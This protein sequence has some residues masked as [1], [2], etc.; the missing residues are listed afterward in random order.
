MAE[1]IETMMTI[2]DQTFT[3]ITEIGNY[4][5]TSEAFERHTKLMRSFQEKG[6]LLISTNYFPS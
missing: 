4:P 3:F 1:R 6:A 2:N 5:S